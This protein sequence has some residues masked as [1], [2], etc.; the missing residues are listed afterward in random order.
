MG[1]ISAAFDSLDLNPI[2]KAFSK[3]KNLAEKGT[4][5]NH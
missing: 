2:E 4:G 5:Q 1:F 3:L